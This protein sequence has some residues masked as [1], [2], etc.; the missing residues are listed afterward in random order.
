MSDQISSRCSDCSH[1]CCNNVSFIL[2]SSIPIHISNGK[3]FFVLSSNKAISSRSGNFSLNNPSH[4]NITASKLC[5]KAALEVEIDTTLWDGTSSPSFDDT[6]SLSD[7]SSPSIYSSSPLSNS[8]PLEEE[9]EIRL[10]SFVLTF[11][12]KVNCFTPEN[13]IFN[14]ESNSDGYLLIDNSFSSC[15]LESKYKRGHFWRMWKT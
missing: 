9:D 14:K 8:L 1:T 4:A 6:D 13:N 3:I 5:P 11:L 12:T 7:N 10:N 15:E 2:R